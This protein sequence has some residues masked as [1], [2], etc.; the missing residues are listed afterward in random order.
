MPEWTKSYVISLVDVG[1]LAGEILDSS[2]ALQLI[3]NGGEPDGAIRFTE[4]DQLVIA[5]YAG[6]PSQAVQ[7][8]LDDAVA[9]H[10]YLSAYKEK[11]NGSVDGETER[12]IAL[13]FEY[14]A[15]SGKMFSL[16]ANAQLNWLGL[17][18]K[19]V[20]LTYPYTIR[21]IDE[22]DAY[23]IVNEADAHAMV[24]AAFVA[25]ETMLTLGRIVKTVVEAA[26]SVAAVDAAAASWLGGGSP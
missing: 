5:V 16:S 18:L 14:P 26:A 24:N 11:I 10:D 1:H 4:P 21:T 15:S 8:A 25:K 2:A 12:R 23:N 6:E 9:T 3:G 20:L 17:E 13:G 19:A 22:H 7:D